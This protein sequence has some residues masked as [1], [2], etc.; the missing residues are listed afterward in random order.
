[1]TNYELVKDK[2]YKLLNYYLSIT[3]ECKDPIEFLLLMCYF[4]IGACKVINEADLSS[5]DEDKLLIWLKVEM[6]VLHM[7]YTCKSEN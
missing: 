5:S 3:R 4:M 6:T 7:P 2:L 1:M